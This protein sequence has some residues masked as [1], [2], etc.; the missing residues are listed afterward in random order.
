MDAL[1]AQQLRQVQCYGLFA[2]AM[3][4]SH[5]VP[6]LARHYDTLQKLVL[7]CT[8]NISRI[9][10]ACVF[11][12]CSN[13]ENL[14]IDCHSRIG[15]LIELSDA[16]DG[17]W[18]C[19]RLRRLRLSISGCG[20]PV[21]AG[22]KPYYSRSTPITLSVD[23][24]R[25]FARLNSLYQRIG[26]LTE[27]RELD[28]T[29]VKGIRQRYR[30]ARPGRKGMFHAMLSLGDAEAGRP[31]FLNHLAGLSKLEA[32]EGSVHLYEQ[33]TKVTVGWEEVRWMDIHWPRLVKARFFTHKKHVSRFNG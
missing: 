23:E 3:T 8:V 32:F 18:N 17:S 9:S 25:H 15:I 10:I 31:G 33:E 26:A 21:E 6:R 16:I 12:E 20:L 28:L 5:N 19:L 4:L 1:P 29:M 30:G 13:L 24:T 11:W 7:Q 2:E 14:T 22:V 27:L